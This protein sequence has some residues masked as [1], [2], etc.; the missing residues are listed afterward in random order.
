MTAE[1]LDTEGSIPPSELMSGQQGASTA[2][3]FVDRLGIEH[4]GPFDLRDL[5]AIF[6]PTYAATTRGENNKRPSHA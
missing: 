4:E 1:N 2:H 6:R 5:A 3:R